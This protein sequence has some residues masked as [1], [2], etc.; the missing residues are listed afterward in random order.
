MREKKSRRWLSLLLAVVMLLSLLPSAV[1]A[2]GETGSTFYRI[3]HLDCGRKYFS[4][5]EI[6]GIVDELAENNYTHL[7]LAFGN[8]GLRFL[9]DD[10][11]VGSY[12]SDEVTNAIKS[13]NSTY[14]SSKSTESTALTEAEMDEIIA[15]ADNAGIEIIPL[16][17][18]PG[19]LNVLLS[20]MKT[21][22]VS[23]SSSF[24][25]TD[26]AQVSFTQELVGKYITYFAGKGCTF[27]NMGADEYSF[28]SLDSDGYAAFV[29]YINTIAA[30]IKDAR[31]KP[32]AFNDGIYYN[33]DDTAF[34]AEAAAIDKDI[35]VAYWC[36]AS[37]YAS[38]A[39]LAA[40]GF[41]LLNNNSNWYYVLGDALYG[42][43]AQGQ[44][45]Y[46]D[47]KAALQNTPCTTFDTSDSTGAEAIGSVMC[48]WCDY[49]K[50]DYEADK[51]YDLIATMA[52]SNPDYFVESGTPTDPDP[53]P[54]ETENED[55]VLT[56]K[57]TGIEVNFGTNNVTG[58]TVEELTEAPEIPGAR[59]VRA[60]S[61]TPESYTDSATVSIPVPTTW[62]N[63]RGGVMASESGE[64]VLDIEGTLSNGV[65]TFVAP[66]FSDVVVYDLESSDVVPV[67][68]SDTVNLT[69]GGSD[70]R[71]IT[72]A[73]Y[74]GTYTTE[75]PS[76]ATV[77]VTGG[78]TEG[79]PAQKESTT[80]VTSLTAGTYI[81]GDGTHW[82]TLS[83][84]T[85]GYTDV[86]SEATQWTIS[87][88]GSSWRIQS[89]NYYLRHSYNNLT[90]STNTY[91]AT[92]SYNSTGFYYSIG[93][94]TTNTY[95]L[96]WSGSAWQVSTTNSNN[97]AAYTYT[98]GQEEVPG[99]DYTEITFKGLAVG[100]TYV[101]VG[102]TRY[103]IKVTDV[104]LSGVDDL[105]IQLW[106]T[107]LPISVNNITT[108]TSGDFRY[109][110]YASGTDYAAHY[111]SVDADDAY[112]ENGVELTSLVPTGVAADGSKT[113]NVDADAKY[114][115]WKG[116]V[117]KKSGSGLQALWST[118]KC[119]SGTPFNY[120]RYYDGAWGVSADRVSW[121]EV[122]GNGSTGS[123]STCTEQII[124]YYMQR[125]KIT[126]QVITDVVDY[127][128]VLSEQN[129][130]HGNIYNGQYVI[131]DYAVNANGTLIPSTFRQDGKTLLY[132]CAGDDENDDG[133]AS[134]YRRLYSIKATETSAYEVYMITITPTRESTSD[135]NFTAGEVPTTYTYKG[136]ERVVWAKTEEDIPDGYATIADSDYS[137][138]KNYGAVTYGGD[139]II[140]ELY[141]YNLQGMLVTYYVRGVQ[142]EDS[143]TVK[144]MD[145]TTGNVFYTTY[146]DVLVETGK[147]K[148]FNNALLDADGNA[149]VVPGDTT[150]DDNTYYII[151]SYNGNVY[152]RSDLTKIPD[153][154]GVYSTGIYNQVRA[155]I[156]PNDNKVLILHYTYDAT[157]NTYKNFV[158]DFGLPVT[159]DAADLFANS[160][161]ITSIAITTGG[162]YGTAE[163]AGTSF[164]YT[165]T[166]VLK[167]ADVVKIT[168]T[169]QDNTTSDFKIG[170][171]PA[172]NVLY[173][174]GFMKA[175][176]TGSNESWSGGGSKLNGTTNNQAAGTSTSD[177]NVYGYDSAYASVTGAS[178]T[179]Y[180]ATVDAANTRTN[181]L[182]F[183]F[184]GT[185]FDLI[186]TCGPA[187]G[188][189]LV[190]V[191]DSDGKYVMG[192][193]VDTSYSVTKLYQVPLVHAQ[194]WGED[195]YTVTVRGAYINYSANSA[196]TTSYN[197]SRGIA[198][199]DPASAISD[200]SDSMGFTDDEA[201]SVEYVNMEERLGSTTYTTRSGDITTMTL[202]I[203]GF[204]VYRT[205]DNSAY[206]EGERGAAYVNVLHATLNGETFTAYVE[207]EDGKSWT[208][209]TY[210]AN[211]GPQNEVYLSS[212]DA[213]AFKV[214]NAETTVQISA[215]A[216]GTDSANLVVNDTII[217][218]SI[219]SNTEMY[220]KV[221]SDK[222]GII[223]IRNN[224]TGMLALGNLKLPAGADAV[225][226]SD[227]D[228]AIVYTWL[229]TVPT[230][231][232]PEVSVFEPET[233]S[234]RVRS[235]GVIRNKLVTVTITASTDVAKLTVNG[236]ELWPIN[237]RQVKS[238]RS[239]NYIYVFTDTMKR[240]DTRTYEIVAYDA[241]GL[242]SEVYTV[243]G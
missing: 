103:T 112:G 74:A 110:G 40:N 129:S 102:D 151:D 200:L 3:F 181:D 96:R 177:P 122:T 17:N 233:L 168:V 22:G 192:Y 51:V 67:T 5:S 232:E 127:G 32:V 146:F 56:D 57:T 24:S 154:H 183:T 227:E 130:S 69:V 206:L 190:R 171:V 20:A 106:I 62:T 163:A 54:E 137:S 135:K 221:T 149:Y 132:H 239:K 85:I 15:Y 75:D 196:S 16:L 224:G 133:L 2:S 70:T 93:I 136:T 52:A 204:R 162:I 230:P 160:S 11:S 31:M 94:I 219:T 145:D 242:A 43:W 180:K 165:P 159:V 65:F 174:D 55:V 158:I 71:E 139:P 179:Q 173:E 156:D 80:K 207:N 140:D 226:L 195:T 119:N 118:N 212:S 217:K 77:E 114:I 142:T 61:I 97:A 222:N 8:D 78:T 41:S 237:S 60:Y 194:D 30:A 86:A 98:P 205:S 231:E 82:M 33:S 49:P 175:D 143:L 131:L 186:G 21:L 90:A 68:K 25:L 201:D 223:A 29:D 125:T 99:N 148:D 84:T 243:Q 117:L 12:T 101:N 14:S 193:L 47:S 7:Q 37:R 235:S 138:N 182:T 39:T 48:V 166:E 155:E 35:I 38:A 73:N 213:I 53:D 113:T 42:V 81:I 72:G 240:T 76:I 203:D 64:E 10:M 169:Y 197:L 123:Y 91:N 26:P 36:Q 111:V 88:S 236:Q 218:E 202:G 95:Y 172:S 44:W 215:R 150:L 220:Y 211:G 164:T 144:Y 121:T 147:T 13:G 234:V 9:L 28:S 152:V 27:F 214:G 185:G 58:M 83:G 229:R 19:H 109:N 23:S 208:K 210:E 46:K 126:D 134:Q 209:T 191:E 104:D 238:G 108:P 6:E 124:A 45:G 241:D 107:S 153:L 189:L 141:I 198:A 34:A 199:A 157:A 228:E 187:T 225:A 4:V 170:F 59:E 63:V 18:T 188:T 161:N 184:T 178:G 128:D 87:Q 116:T 89:G 120:V 50:Y 100:T 216:V 176:T 66:H 105:P 79:T 92:W 167:N 1:L 115:I